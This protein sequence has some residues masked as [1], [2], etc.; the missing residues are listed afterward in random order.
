MHGVRYLRRETKCIIFRF[1]HILLDSFI[2]NL[3]K[4]KGPFRSGLKKRGRLETN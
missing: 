2:K 4:Q 1:G 3:R